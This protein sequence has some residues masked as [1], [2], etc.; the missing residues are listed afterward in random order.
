MSCPS[1]LI[2][3]AAKGVVAVEV[4]E[5]G[6]REGRT[7]ARRGGLG[8]PASIVRMSG[9]ASLPLDPRAGAQAGGVACQRSAGRPA[10][11]ILVWWAR[12]AVARASSACWI[13]VEGWWRSS[14]SESWVR[15]S[16]SGWRM[17]AAW[18]CSAS[19]SPVACPSVHAAA[20]PG[21]CRRWRSPWTRRSSSRGPTAGARSRRRSSSP[22]TWRRRWRRARCWSRSGCR[23]SARG[24]AARTRSSTGS[25]PGRSSAWPRW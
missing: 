16:P 3:L 12:P 10:V 22:T 17:S 4:P 23:C 19:G 14:R 6:C 8:F 1:A 13:L 11:R 7:G 5:V 21:T 20:R 15:V 25:R 18:S 2:G 9:A 24:G